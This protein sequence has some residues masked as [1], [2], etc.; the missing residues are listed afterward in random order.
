MPALLVLL[1]CDPGSTVQPPSKVSKG[2]TLLDCDIDAT[3]HARDADELFNSDHVPSFDLELPEDKWAA[4]QQNA[5]DE[6]WEQ[7]EACFDGKLIGR[8]ALRFKGSHGSLFNCFDDAGQLLCPRLSMKLKFSEYDEDSRFFGLKRLNLHANRHD[9]SRMKERLA[10][11]LY[12]A[13]GV[14]APRASW[15]LA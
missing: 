3:L 10:Y 8:V 6:Q 2:S 12:R 4:L 14:A 7:A 11:D 13:M 5:V 15:A 9:D 1:G